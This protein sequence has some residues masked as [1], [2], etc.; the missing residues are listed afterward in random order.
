MAELAEEEEEDAP[1]LGMWTFL[2]SETTLFGGLFTAYFYERRLWGDA[3]RAAAERTD[4]PL[5]SLNTA[6]LLS[7]SLSMALAVHAARDGR[8]AALRARL[9]ATMVLGAAFLALKALEYAEHVLD[10]L[11]P[12]P[13][14]V[15]SPA[16]LSRPA[17]LFFFLYFSMTGL[18]ALHMFVGLGWLGGLEALSRRAPERPPADAVEAAGLYWHFVDMVWIFLFPLFYLAKGGR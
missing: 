11:W 3:F 16:P 8:A 17:E 7:S 4:L 1:R 13:A 9:R 6:L 18:H 15:F 10:G 2:M 14:F 12:G 5:G